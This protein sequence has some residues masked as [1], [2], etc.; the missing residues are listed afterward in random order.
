MRRAGRAAAM[1]WAAGWSKVAAATARAR[2]GATL[3]VVLSV[4]AA[5]PV[6]LVALVIS[7]LAFA[8]LA[9]PLGLATAAWWVTV[10]PRA[11]NRD[12]PSAIITRL[13]EGTFRLSAVSEGTAEAETPSRVSAASPRVSRRHAPRVGANPPVDLLVACFGRAENA[14]DGSGDAARAVARRIA[15]V[16]ASE[17]TAEGEGDGRRHPLSTAVVDV[18]AL[19][20]AAAANP[21]AVGEKPDP[22]AAP[23]LFSVLADG[24]ARAAYVFDSSESSRDGLR[25]LRRALRANPHGWNATKRKRAT[26]FAFVS[27]R[28][29]ARGSGSGNPS[30][31]VSAPR[32]SFEGNLLSDFERELEALLFKDEKVAAPGA[33]ASLDSLRRFCARCDADFESNG[34]GAVD[35]WTREV[36]IP[37]VFGAPPV[38]PRILS[39]SSAHTAV[40]VNHLGARSRVVGCDP[41]FQD[42]LAR[43][44]GTPLPRIDPFAPD[45]ESVKR[46]RPSLVV[47]AYETTAQALREAA[48]AG[49]A[50]GDARESS[51]TTTFEIVTL[52]CPLGRDAIEQTAAQIHELAAYARVDDAVARRASQKLT[53][54]LLAIREKAEKAFG[55]SYFLAENGSRGPRERASW[56]RPQPWIFIEADP[57]LYS[58]DSWTPLGAA[59]ARGLGVGNIA[60]PIWRDATPETLETSRGGDGEDAALAGGTRENLFEDRVEVSEAFTLAVE[61][62]YPRLPAERFWNPREADWWIVAHPARDGA[63]RASTGEALDG[64]KNDRDGRAALREGRVVVL[65]D[66]MCHAASQWTPDLVDVVAAVFAAMAT[67]YAARELTRARGEPE[68][69]TDAETTASVSGSMRTV[70]A[71]ARERDDDREEN[72]AVEV[73]REENVI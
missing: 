6:V 43:V 23:D 69:E 62:H 70:R 56:S 17:T 52:A 45:L 68:E 51:T 36:L 50:E 3:A 13:R 71:N 48:R 34:P 4:T 8:A 5:L 1:E 9:L 42:P 16:V 49:A 28:R 19:C 15:D 10:R 39:L 64:N 14:S 59:L 40:L 22:S 53:R 18:E 2:P 12:S 27:L 7:A 58:A 21:N 24:A 46:L 63:V 32:K 60:D 57:E 55:G 20:A 73:D 47:C 72:D 61:S 37:A 26:P 41:W 29:S 25:A 54:G 33:A 44:Q 30:D 31:A 67:Y 35:R 65:S 66:A 11:R 38:P